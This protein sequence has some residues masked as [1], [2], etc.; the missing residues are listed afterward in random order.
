MRPYF[1]K[2]CTCTHGSILRP[3]T[4]RTY[5]KSTELS[6]IYNFP[7]PTPTSN[8]VVGVL[9]FG[10]GLVGTVSPS[11]VLTNGDCQEHWAYL[12][13]SPANFPKVIIVP[14]NGAT[15]QPD[16]TDGATIENTI[17]VETIGA[18]CPSSKLTILLYLVPNSLSQFTNI[19][20]KASGPTVI[21]G[22]SYTPSVISCS[23]GTSESNFPL[24]LLNSL[25]A[26]L[27]ALSNRGVVFTA[28]TGDYGSSNGGPGNNCDFPSSSPYVI[29]CGG[30]SLVCPNYTYDSSTVET[31][32]SS[33]GGGISKFFAKPAYQSALNGSGRSTPDIALVA[34]PNTGVVYTIGS[35]LQ[36]IGGTSIVSP[37]MAAYA[38][39]LNLNR[40]IT[41]LLYTFP[42]SDFHDI[43]QGSNGAFSAKTG[44]DNCTGLG[45]I[46]GINLA[47]SLHGGNTGIPVTGITVAPTTLQL[48]VGTS[49]TLV[50]TVSPANATTQTVLWSSSNTNV[51]SISGSTVTAVSAGT[52]TITAMTADRGFTATCSVTVNVPYVP[53]ASVTV[54][55]RTATISANQTVILTAAPSPSNATNKTVTWSSSNT[56]VA[57]VALVSNSIIYLR[58][59]V[60]NN[61]SA[62]VTGV[63]AGTATITATCP[64]GNV[65]AT[66]LITILQPIRNLT[67]VPASLLMTVGTTSQTNVVFTPSQSAVPITNWSSSNSNVASV[68]SSGLVRAIRNGT[69]TITA[70]VNGIRATRVVTVR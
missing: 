65:H 24:S 47:N 31:G 28:A 17:D 55:P 7:S 40:A 21:D 16:A 46:H 3:R 62:L 70:T 4:S 30:T 44:Y 19:I 5:F 34:D 52:A 69:A 54:N 10:G 11:G 58:P 61:L 13:I 37:A 2:N 43:M 49:S 14:L 8:L 66:A 1:C 51:A 48:N 41:P 15:N 36:V 23:W 63:S 27:Q 50:A 32:W 33:G 20:A 45:S 18:M 35:S 39:I 60:T 59:S 25:N 29:A 56:A 6:T 67:L 38:A 53:V 12:G 42:A 26:Q 9:S 22:V 64:S 57:T 68:S